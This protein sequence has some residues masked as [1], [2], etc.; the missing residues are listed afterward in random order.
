MSEPGGDDQRFLHEIERQV[1]RTQKA[2]GMTFWQGLAAIGAVGWMV[3][4]P[5]VVGAF[6]GRWLDQRLARGVF[7]T[8]SLLL[9]GLAIGCV[10]AWRHVREELS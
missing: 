7:W 10:T 5:A 3:V 4:I 6:V 1:A 8:L 9:T 2:R